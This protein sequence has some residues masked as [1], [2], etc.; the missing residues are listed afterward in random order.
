M[1]K[2]LVS[3]FVVTYQEWLNWIETG[4]IRCN[5]SRIVPQ[6]DLKINE[7]FAISM[8]AAP[9]V[10]TINDQAYVVARLKAKYEDYIAPVSS[11][12]LDGTVWLKLE[13]VEQFMP[14]TERG[15]R[16]IKA[17]ARRAWVRI[18]EA[19]YQSSWESW[20]N[21]ARQDGA[22]KRGRMLVKAMGL[23]PP[24]LSVVSKTIQRYLTGEKEP[25][26]KQPENLRATRA[27]AWTR[28]CS[29]YAQLAG[30][31]QLTEQ[32]KKLGIIK[33][34]KRLCKDQHIEKP[35]TKD[36]KMLTIADELDVI[37]KKA[38]GSDV[39]MRFLATVFHYQEVL[40]LGSNVELKSLVH[41]IKEVASKHGSTFAA[42]AAYYVGLKMKDIE[43]TKIYYASRPDDFPALTPG[44]LPCRIKV[45]IKVKQPNKKSK[46]KSRKT[47]TESKQRP[48]DN[49]KG[50]KKK[51]KLST[52]R[53]KKKDQLTLV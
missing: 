23:P 37:V 42:N 39:P 21:E 19:S 38:C 45:S 6:N 46:L 22:D 34:L 53:S 50:G 49:A 41:D 48:A 18:G 8:N 15:G 33:A 36:K 17:D 47:K 13:A 26:V 35:I 44:P 16:L 20:T 2:L 28:A 3:M 12:S 11:P 30:K 24:D 25:P 29:T 10:S 51:P 27:M 4:R 40:Y 9:D 43:V 52:K 5:S 31:D 32:S 14:V 7:S 1:G